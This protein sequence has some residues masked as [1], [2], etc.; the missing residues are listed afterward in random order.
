MFEIDDDV[1]DETVIT[2]DLSIAPHQL[3][4]RAHMREAAVLAACPPLPSTAPKVK[5][6]WKKGQKRVG[7]RGKKAP[8]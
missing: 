7:V 5:R 3:T 4:V 1:L 6:G 2:E 8:A